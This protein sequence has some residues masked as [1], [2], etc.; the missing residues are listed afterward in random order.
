MVA[1]RWWADGDQPT[2]GRRRQATEMCHR[3]AIGSPAVDHWWKFAAYSHWRTD[4]VV[5]SGLVGL[6]PSFIK[7]IFNVFF[8]IS[9]LDILT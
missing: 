8:S 4:G 2:V 6:L 3:L 9:D 5:L 7:N 1:R